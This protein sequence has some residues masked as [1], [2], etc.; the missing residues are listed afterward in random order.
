MAQELEFVP[1]C[2]DLGVDRGGISVEAPSSCSASGDLCDKFREFCQ[3]LAGRQT[4]ESDRGV[5]WRGRFAREHVFHISAEQFSLASPG[6]IQSLHGHFCRSG[7]TT[8]RRSCV[9]ARS[10]FGLRGPQDSTA[11]LSTQ[12]I[13]NPLLAG[14]WLALCNFDPGPWTKLTA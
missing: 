7:E 5:L 11:C 9:T 1:V 8:N 4:R 3:A 6:K 14:P 10:E 2:S 13:P 12:S